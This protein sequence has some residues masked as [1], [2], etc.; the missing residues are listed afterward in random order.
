MTF[1]PSAFIAWLHRGLG[2]LLPFRP[3]CLCLLVGILGLAAGIQAAER[4]IEFS[5]QS[6]AV[7]PSGWETFLYGRGAPPRWEIQMQAVTPVFEPITDKAPVVDRVPVLAQLSQDREDE[8]YPVITFAEERFGDFT[9]TF[10][11]R[12]S[13][14]EMEQLAGLVFRS[15]DNR[16]FYVLRLSVLG[17]NVRFYKV[18]DGQRSP[19]VG[20]DLPLQTGKWYEM[21]VRCRGHQIDTWLD[22]VELLPTLTDASFQAGRIGFMTKS[23]TIAQFGDLH[24]EYRPL[25]S[26]AVVLVE[27]IVERYPRLTDL[28]IFGRNSDTD[29]LEVLAAKNREDIGRPAGNTEQKVFQENQMYFLRTKPT[30]IVTTPIRDRNGDVLGVA[31]F[32]LKR[33]PGQTDST[34]LSR[35]QPMMDRIQQRIGSATSLA[36]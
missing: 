12:I 29:A 3:W 34:S 36:E 15:V 10:R 17:G 31:E 9:L 35:V 8:R 7:L 5:S 30:A 1:K 28:R 20:R 6:E 32:H 16:N 25:K 4:R 26:L 27:D 11:M 18:I 13:G 19:P 14:G 23:D 21:K 33:L 22:G 24:I 2:C